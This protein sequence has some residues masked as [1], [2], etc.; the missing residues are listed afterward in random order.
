[1]A[2][3]QI[4]ACDKNFRPLREIIPNLSATEL[5]SLEEC[6]GCAKLIDC[7]L[8]EHECNDGNGHCIHHMPIANI[9]KGGTAYA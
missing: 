9:L 2:K 4:G 1:M 5:I 6:F 7:D 3:Y 8:S